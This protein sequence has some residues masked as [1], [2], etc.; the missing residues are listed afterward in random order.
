[1]T[2]RDKFYLLAKKLFEEGILKE[3]Y[4]SE[5]LSLCNVGNA[6]HVAFLL[7]ECNKSENI[8]FVIVPFAQIKYVMRD[9]KSLYELFNM[10]PNDAKKVYA[11]DD[12]A[13]NTMRNAKNRCLVEG[14]RIDLE[15]EQRLIRK[16]GNKNK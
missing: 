9:E 5:T 15:E 10:R 11:F 13:H 2:R 3:I 7:D 4:K 12:R 1:M 14:P 8:Q 6:F 16:Y